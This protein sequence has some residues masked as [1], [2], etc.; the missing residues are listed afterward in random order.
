[1]RFASTMLAAAVVA[2]AAVAFG[3]STASA[4]VEVSDEATGEHCSAVTVDEN[5]NVSG[6][7][8][9]EAVTERET[10]VYAWVP[11]LGL[12]TV[13]TCDEHFEAA[14]GEDGTGYLYSAT[15]TQHQG[16]YCR[17][18]QCDEADHANRPWPLTIE[19]TGRMKFYY[20]VRDVIG[21]SEGDAGMVCYSTM[22]LVDNFI[23]HQELVATGTPGDAS[24]G[25]GL[26]IR[27][28]A[29]WNLVP[30]ISHPAIEINY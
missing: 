8:R 23:H 18:V 9:V 20:C 21:T 26:D 2:L 1:M 28:Q 13:S 14:I 10:V 24:C 19:S 5:H 30:T 3:A 15:H 25:G 22:D 27:I 7:C 12:V 11:P 6:G 17:S 29:H 16:T 4:Q